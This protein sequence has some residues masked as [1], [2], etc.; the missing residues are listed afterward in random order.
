TSAVA[1]LTGAASAASR[2]SRASRYAREPG[3]S[4]TWRHASSDADWKSGGRSA[5]VPPTLVE[6]LGLQRR[7]PEAAGPIKGELARRARRTA[8]RRTSV[9]GKVRSDSLA[10]GHVRPAAHH[11][12]AHTSRRRLRLDD[13]HRG[14]EP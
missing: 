12:A 9:H 6:L 14:F 3:V 5:T 11:P 1:P 2:R 13:H 8:P 7:A 10:S 4:R